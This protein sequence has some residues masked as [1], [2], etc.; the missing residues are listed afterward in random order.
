V[1]SFLWNKG[2]NTVL[3]EIM[4]AAYLIWF[5]TCVLSI[6]ECV[7]CET[8]NQMT[9]QWHLLDAH[10][11]S[12]PKII[13]YYM[14]KKVVNC[15]LCVNLKCKFLNCI[16]NYHS[17]FWKPEKYDVITCLYCIVIAANKEGLY[18]VL[19]RL[20]KICLSP[21]LRLVFREAKFCHISLQLWSFIKP[22]LRKM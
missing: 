19:Q 17:K 13:L 7:Q 11:I 12:L 15:I 16:Q 20:P 4:Y 6:C 10:Y 14:R 21:V 5:C 22:S 9:V 2:D 1:N 18:F 8:V 3:E